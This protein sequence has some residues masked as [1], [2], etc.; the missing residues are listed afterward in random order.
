M[1]GAELQKF[2]AEQQALVAA[3]NVHRC[4]PLIQGIARASPG[5]AS[6]VLDMAIKLGPDQLV[7][8]IKIM[9]RME[10]CCAPMLR[11]TAALNAWTGGNAKAVFLAVIAIAAYAVWRWLFPYAPSPAAAAASRGGFPDPTLGDGFDSFSGAASG[12][13]GVDNFD[14]FDAF[15]DG[16]V[17]ADA[18][19][20]AEAAAAAGA[21]SD[22]DFDEYD[23]FG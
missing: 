16:D 10:R 8:M 7:S 22:F 18:P 13:G 15:D 1:S 12:A 14:T 2:A 23:E 6:A 11:C 19:V 21:A 5:Q 4:H 20:P 3:N 17:F 9:E